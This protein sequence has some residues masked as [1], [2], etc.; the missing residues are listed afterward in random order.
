[1]AAPDRGARRSGSTRRQF[2]LGGAVAGVGA[3]AA[4]GVDLAL[5]STSDAAAPATP[6][7]SSQVPSSRYP[8]SVSPA[9]GW[10][11]T[12]HSGRVR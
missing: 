8:P 2:L 10:N 1:M 11:C 7:R 9:S 5:N 12:P 6:V 4:I 3:A